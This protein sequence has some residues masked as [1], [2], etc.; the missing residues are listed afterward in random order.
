MEFWT[1]GI[2]TALSKFPFAKMHS[3]KKFLD[4]SAVRLF[5]FVDCVV[6]A[7]LA[8]LVSR[9]ALRELQ[10]NDATFGAPLASDDALR[11]PFGRQWNDRTSG[12]L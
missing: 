8:S 2:P 5:L 11:A 10:V 3:R 1:D 6:L 7:L 12:G 4:V 9:N